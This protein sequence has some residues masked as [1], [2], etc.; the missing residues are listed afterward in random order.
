MVFADRL[1]PWRRVVALLGHRGAAQCKGALQVDR[2]VAQY[3]VPRA[4]CPTGV[5]VLAR[6]LHVPDYSTTLRVL[7]RDLS[8]EYRYR[9]Y[10]CTRVLMAERKS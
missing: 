1:D 3:C 10:S 5:C 8:R 4:A 6:L 2:Q 9:R 7:L